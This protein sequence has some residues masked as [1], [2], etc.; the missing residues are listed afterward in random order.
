MRLALLVEDLVLRRTSATGYQA[1]CN[2]T[3]RRYTPQAKISHRIISIVLEQV[4]VFARYVIAV[5]HFSFLFRQ[6]ICPSCLDVPETPLVVFVKAHSPSVLLCRR[7]RGRPHTCSYPYSCAC[8][9]QEIG[10]REK[11]RRDEFG[12]LHRR[13][14]AKHGLIHFTPVDSAP[15]AQYY[16]Y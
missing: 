14:A 15:Y 5:S 7:L 9:A 12:R 11:R 6:L 8:A 16:V 3:K 2:K 4:I 1:S 13:A 10:C